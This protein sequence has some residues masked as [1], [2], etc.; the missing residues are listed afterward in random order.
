MAMVAMQY[1][2]TRQNSTQ[3]LPGTARGDLVLQQNDL[4]AEIAGWRQTAFEPAKSPEELPEG[5]FWWTHVWKYTNGPQ[6]GIVTF[7]QA[8]FMHWHD[9]TVCYRGIGW[10][11]ADKSVLAGTADTQEWPCVVA[12]MNKNETT[13][14]LL[15][16]SLFFDDGDPVDARGYEAQEKSRND[17]WRL[18]ESRFESNR[19]TSKVASIRQCQVLVP[20]SGTLDSETEA[21]IIALHLQTREAFREKWLKHWNSEKEPATNPGEHAFVKPN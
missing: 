16:F 18:L 8:D 1:F 9:L 2:S 17:F 21:S 7:D 4:P 19:R 12:R 20:Y 10:T 15:V 14:A 3:T 6:N 5:Q 11:V 13:S